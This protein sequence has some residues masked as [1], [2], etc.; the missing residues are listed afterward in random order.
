MDYTIDCKNKRLGRIATEIALILQ[1][2]K[3]PSYDP[4]KEGDDRAIIKN[5]DDL[6]VSG[7]KEEK[8]IYYSH[9][10]QIG[11]LKERSYKKVVAVRGKQWVLRRAVERMLPKNRL[12]ARRM[13]HIVFE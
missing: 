9:T 7:D 2:K 8:K 3:N 4:S 6:E 1:G 13:K 10:T 11:H 12:R 5:I